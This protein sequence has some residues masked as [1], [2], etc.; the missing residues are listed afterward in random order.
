[1][2]LNWLG[3]ARYCKR[4]VKI[5][6]KEQHTLNITRQVDLINL[7]EGYEAYSDLLT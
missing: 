3:E 7:R 1:M 6:A 5:E 4:F 2:G